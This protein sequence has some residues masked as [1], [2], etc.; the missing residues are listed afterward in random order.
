M[1]PSIVVYKLLAMALYA[2]EGY[3]RPFRLLGAEGFQLIVVG[4]LFEVI[5]QCIRFQGHSTARAR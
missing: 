5:E 2:G 1:L 3:R 4:I